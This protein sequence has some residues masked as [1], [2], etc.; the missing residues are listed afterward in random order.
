MSNMSDFTA[1]LLTNE[2]ILAVS[3]FG[4][5]PHMLH[6]K[7]S[8]KGVKLTLSKCDS[9]STFQSWIATVS[10]SAIDA[11]RLHVTYADVDICMRL[12]VWHAEQ[13]DCDSKQNNTGMDLYPCTTSHCDGHSN[14][15]L[16]PSEGLAAP[17]LN[18]WSHHCLDGTA[19]KISTQPCVDKSEQ[20]WV[21]TSNNGHTLLRNVALGRCL[22][23]SGPPTPPP[24]PV[25]PPTPPAPTPAP[26]PGE[27]QPVWVT[28]MLGG[29]AYVAVFNKA[30]EI[31]S[32]TFQLEDVVSTPASHVAVRNV[33]TK[34]DVIIASD[35]VTVSV[36]SH[37]VTFLHI[38]DVSQNLVL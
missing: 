12:M 28:S 15:W 2:D 31:A 1:G 3:E 38:T 9:N 34:H 30:D 36:A 8:Y 24:T 10:D 20:Q 5:R 17:V 11:I 13:G 37:G 14:A 19:G 35:R 6:S 7:L 21:V 18:A 29:S 27:D 4:I 32:V 16:L 23:F 33:W 26:A 22:S 25:P